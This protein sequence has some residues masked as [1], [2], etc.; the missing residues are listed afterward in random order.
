[1]VILRLESSCASDFAMPVK[2]ALVAQ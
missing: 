2:P 1:M